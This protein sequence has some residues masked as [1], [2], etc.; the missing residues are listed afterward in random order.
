MATQS[1]HEDPDATS[2]LSPSLQAGVFVDGASDVGGCPPLGTER[3]YVSE[4]AECRVGQ[5]G[6][7]FLRHDR[8]CPAATQGTQAK[9]EDDER[10]HERRKH[11]EENGGAERCKTYDGGND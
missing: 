7:V 4:P 8:R 1:Y 10:P 3:N 2:P 6:H 5:I 11:N 9:S